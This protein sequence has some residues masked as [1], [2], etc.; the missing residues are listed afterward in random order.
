MAY[1]VKCGVKL[2]ETEKQCPLCHTVVCHPDIAPATAPSLYPGG[3][4]P[5]SRS[6]LQALGGVIIILS[7]VPLLISLFSDLQKDGRLDWFGYVAGAFVVSYV[8]LA[9][10]LWFK[11]PN[12]LIFVPCSFVA[13]A[14]YLWHINVATE[15]Q[16][17]LSFALP[18]VAGLCAITCAVIAL[19]HYVK[20]GRLY[21]FG[22]AFILLGGWVLL[23]EYL[24][25]VTFGVAFVGWSVYPLVVLVLLGVLLVYLAVSRN[26]R[27][28]LERK[29]FF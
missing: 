10:P 12:P 21:I 23:A 3:K 4:R 16:W 25:T 1:C 22:G 24:L 26:A 17:Y 20:R 14:L 13:S 5:A 2:A 28:T 27:E 19:T 8:T 7:L 11:K 18:L 9:L 6:G 29:L 15:G